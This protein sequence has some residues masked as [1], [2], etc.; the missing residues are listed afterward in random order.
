MKYLIG[1]LLMAFCSCSNEADLGAISDVKNPAKI[2]GQAGNATVYKL[3]DNSSTYIIVV[4]DASGDV[5]ITQV[6]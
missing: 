3:T 6:K 2:I 1:I 4:G 5:A